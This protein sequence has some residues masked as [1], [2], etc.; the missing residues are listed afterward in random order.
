[1]RELLVVAA[2]RA[3]VRR[4]P[5]SHFPCVHSAGAVYSLTTTKTGLLVAGVGSSVVVYEDSVV[6][7]KTTSLDLVTQ[8]GG[9]SVVLDVSVVETASGTFKLAVADLMR[10]VSLLS[11]DPES[12]TLSMIARELS[13]R[14]LSAALLVDPTR[15]VLGDSNFNLGVLEHNTNVN[16]EDIIRLTNIGEQYCGNFI[17]RFRVGRLSPLAGMDVVIFGTISG[18][19]GL[20]APLS[21]EEFTILRHL[22]SSLENVVGCIGGFDVKQYRLPNS[23]IVRADTSD[24][25]GSLIDGDIVE[26][27]LELSPVEQQEA[28]AGLSASEAEQAIALV[29]RLS[30][31]K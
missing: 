20:I 21:K 26:S 5:I 28:L 11:F 2:G 10:S 25:V 17:N 16:D 13:P 8:L 30:R 24:T 3:L 14:W 1:L 12:Q 23:T 29:E 31:L 19:I 27:I 7:G 6:E 18:S 15:V 22:Q 9:F 4:S